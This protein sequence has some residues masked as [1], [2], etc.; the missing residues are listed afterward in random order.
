MGLVDDDQ[1]S[2]R[3]SALLDRLRT[4]DLN[5]FVRAI[6]PVPCLHHAV[7]NVAQIFIAELIDQNDAIANESN[8]GL[9]AMRLVNK[10]RRRSA[11]RRVGKECVSTYRSR[12]SPY[13]KKKKNE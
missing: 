13:H 9:L 1:I 7:R 6:A 3:K 4:A 8:A 2:A 10:M 11:E 5:T 12:W